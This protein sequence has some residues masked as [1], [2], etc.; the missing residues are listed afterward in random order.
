MYVKLILR[1]TFDGVLPDTGYGLFRVRNTGLDEIL[2]R[3]TGIES[4]TGCEIKAYG[5][6]DTEID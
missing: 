2:M 3:D 5:I 1:G 4:H 6:R